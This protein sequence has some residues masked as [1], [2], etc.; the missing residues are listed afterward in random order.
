[1]GLKQALLEG[2]QRI[3]VWGVG[4]IGY[5]TMSNFAERGVKCIGY[6]I[7]PKKVASLGEIPIF[8]VD[9]WLGFDPKFLYENGVARATLDSKE[10]VSLTGQSAVAPGPGAWRIRRCHQW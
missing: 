3:G 10:M 9:Y 1:M 6:D 7:D 2:H 5:S 4:H 8:A